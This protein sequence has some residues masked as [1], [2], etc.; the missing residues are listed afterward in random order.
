MIK[1]LGLAMLFVPM[2]LTW[3]FLGWILWV[4]R[5]VLGE[6]LLPLVL[7]GSLGP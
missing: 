5:D 6:L 2:L 7:A 4:G 1:R 3:A